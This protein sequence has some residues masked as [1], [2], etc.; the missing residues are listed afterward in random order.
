MLILFILRF[1]RIDAGVAQG[2]VAERAEV[3]GIL[4]QN[5]ISI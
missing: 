1:H 4:N 3:L 2:A 5:L